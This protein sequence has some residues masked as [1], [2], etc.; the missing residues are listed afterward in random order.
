[1]PEEA[2]LEEEEEEEEEEAAEIRAIA[3]AL[4]EKM[5]ALVRSDLPTPLQKHKESPKTP[6][7]NGIL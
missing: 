5:A 6:I 2:P 1:M 7:G 4:P 3:G